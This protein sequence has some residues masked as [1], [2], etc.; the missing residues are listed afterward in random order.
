MVDG[1]QKDWRELCVA[2]INETDSTKLASLVQE[3]I[4]ALDQGERAWRHNNPPPD[5]SVTNPKVP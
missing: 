4:H 3:L 5:A 2:V 1:T